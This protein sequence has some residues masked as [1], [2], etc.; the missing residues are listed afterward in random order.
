MQNVGGA[1]MNEHGTVLFHVVLH[2]GWKLRLSDVHDVIIQPCSKGSLIFV[3][4]FMFSI[5]HESERVL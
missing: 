5:M 2:D 4:R 3:L 1:H